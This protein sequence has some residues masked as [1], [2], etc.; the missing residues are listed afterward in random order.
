MAGAK[1]RLRRTVQDRALP[2][3]STCPVGRH[4][5]LKTQRTSVL[6]TKT[7]S[8]TGKI[9]LIFHRSCWIH[10][11]Q[12]GIFYFFIYF[13]LTRNHLLSALATLNRQLDCDILISG[14][15]AHCLW[16]SISDKTFFGLF[17]IRLGSGLPYFSWYKIPKPG[18]IYQITTNFT[19][20]P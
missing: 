10:S 12:S 13:A 19:K 14:Q 7:C 5:R 11:S 9:L 4:W 17:S 1:G 3:T 6:K 2:W 8:R 16:I 15:V 20:C 18:K